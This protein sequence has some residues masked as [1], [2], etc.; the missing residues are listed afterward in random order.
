MAGVRPT[1]ARSGC[2][3]KRQEEAPKS[4]TWS[5]DSS[6]PDPPELSQADIK[7]Q[8]ALGAQS[9]RGSS[10]EASFGPYIDADPHA[11]WCFDRMLKAEERN[12]GEWAVFYHSYRS[13][14]ALAYEVQAAIAAVLFRFRSEYAALPRL[15]RGGFKAIPDAPTLRKNLVKWRGG[16]GNP[17]FKSVA[18]CATT[19]LL[20]MDEEAPPSGCFLEGYSIS[21]T[22]D[23]LL[24][25]MLTACGV[26][27]D[28]AAALVQQIHGL[29][30]KYQLHACHAGHLLQIFMRRHLVDKYAYASHPYGKPDPARHPIGRHLCGG[31]YIAGQVRIVVHPSAFLRAS[32][33]RMNLY[34]ANKA[35][36]QHRQAFQQDLTALL[37][38]VLGNEQSRITAARAIFGGRVPQWFTAEDQRKHRK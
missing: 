17:R 11:R 4:S 31:D 1:D 20:A 23:S 8:V 13:G 12:C 28:R 10:L 30:D 33:V 14:N 36:H 27:K 7:K 29:A 3:R 18:I 15:M 34:S 35:F 22:P 24:V 37:A 9:R 5:Q 6:I 25:A 26:A 2:K 38:P 32:K 19:S 21:D 16:D